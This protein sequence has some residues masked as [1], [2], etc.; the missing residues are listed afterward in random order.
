MEGGVGEG[1]TRDEQIVFK[2][3]DVFEGNLSIWGSTRSRARSRTGGSQRKNLNEDGEEARPP[4][5]VLL[6]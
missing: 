3:C 5:R 6:P 1:E 4:V 2:R